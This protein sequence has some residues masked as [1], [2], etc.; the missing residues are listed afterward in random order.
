MSDNVAAEK[1][2]N[3]N[4]KLGGRL[5]EWRTRH[6]LTLAV[7]SEKT[8]VASSSLSKIE[9]EQ[10]SVSYH[11]LKKIC[12]GLD[13]PIEE[14][15][16]PEHKTFAPGRRS[17]TKASM[18]S[19]FRCRQYIYHAHSTD[20]S[21]KDMIP[22]EMT[23]LARSPNDFEDWNKHEGEEFVYVLSGEI[24]VHTEFYSPIRLKPGDSLYFDSSM[25]HMYVSV[26]PED[27][28]ILSVCYDPRAHQQ[29]DVLDFFKAGRLNVKP[30]EGK[31]A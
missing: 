25:G 11:T 30:L 16:N 13:M 24:E 20:M 7:V 21:K 12:D 4:G 5:R 3:A 29:R 23:V 31:S 2:A 18:G 17:I 19:E 1:R 22:L 9:N 27:A 28:K 15:I 8:G 26:S 6:G 14:I 10:V